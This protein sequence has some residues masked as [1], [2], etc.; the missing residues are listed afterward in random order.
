M[1]IYY[2]TITRI[3]GILTCRPSHVTIFPAAKWE[4][5]VAGMILCIHTMNI[6]MYNIATEMYASSIED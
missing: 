5:E 4:G 3:I 6:A 1:N 2:L